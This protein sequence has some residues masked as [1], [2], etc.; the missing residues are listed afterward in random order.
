MLA[1][2]PFWKI[3]LTLRYRPLLAFHIFCRY[4][5]RQ[6]VE[7]RVSKFNISDSAQRRLVAPRRASSSW[8]RVVCIL[9]AFEKALLL[10]RRAGKLRKGQ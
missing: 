7:G 10:A 3:L 2:P 6:K 9:F 8:G 4:Q 1:K 5:S